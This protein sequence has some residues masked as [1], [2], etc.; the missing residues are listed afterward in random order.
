MAEQRFRSEIRLARR[1]R[2]RNVCTVH[3][4]GEDRGLQFICMELVEGEDLGR[5]A[6]EEERSRSRRRRAWPCRSPRGSGRSTRSASS[7]GT[8]RPRTSCATA[9]GSSA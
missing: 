3:D 5:A 9:T 4:D 7:T 6:R 2:H 1:V 8:S